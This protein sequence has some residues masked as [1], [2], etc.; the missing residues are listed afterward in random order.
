MKGRI[1]SGQNSKLSSTQCSGDNR[2]QN[3]VGMDVLVACWHICAL[4]SETVKAWMLNL[5]SYLLQCSVNGLCTDILTGTRAIRAQSGVWKVTIHQAHCLGP[6]ISLGAVARHWACWLT[7]TQQSVIFHARGASLLQDQQRWALAIATTCPRNKR[8]R[9]TPDMAEVD[10]NR[11]PSTVVRRGDIGTTTLSPIHSGLSSRTI[12]VHP[13][14][15]SVQ[16]RLRWSFQS[17]PRNA[18]SLFP[19]LTLS[20]NSKGTKTWKLW[21]L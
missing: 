21:A 3:S 15:V 16:I 4:A 9:V 17:S 8:S 6:R 2:K 14:P 20:G 7:R 18:P 12:G 11:H 1:E 10:R 19:T 13:R 5:K